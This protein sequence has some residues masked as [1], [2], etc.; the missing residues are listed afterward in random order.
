MGKALNEKRAIIFGGSL[1]EINPNIFKPNVAS[2]LSP[3][4][5]YFFTIGRAS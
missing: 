2:F 5:K 3:N 1:A 4:P